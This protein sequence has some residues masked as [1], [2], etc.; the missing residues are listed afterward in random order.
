[1][2]QIAIG[3]ESGRRV[4]AFR[5]SG[6]GTASLQEG[7]KAN[8]SREGES[9]TINVDVDSLDHLISVQKLPQPDFMKVDVEGLEM[10]VLSGMEDTL[11]Q[12]KPELLIEIHGAGRESKLKNA[13]KI[14]DFLIDQRYSLRHVESNLEITANNFEIAREGHL[15]CF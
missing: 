11:K 2:L 5:M 12:C 1:M 3:K 10:E 4:L 7:L 8:I 9:Q 14:V 6:T 13:G 15:Y